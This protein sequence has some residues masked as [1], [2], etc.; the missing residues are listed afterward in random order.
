MN[1]K[2]IVKDASQIDGWF[3]GGQMNFIHQHLVNLPER[4]LIVEIGTYRGRSTYLVA[5]SVPKSYVITI[6]PC[7]FEWPNEVDKAGFK[8]VNETIDDRA[9]HAGNV[10]QWVTTSQEAAKVFNMPIDFL[11]IDGLHEQCALD[12]ELWLPKV[13]KGGLVAF[14][15]YDEPHPE[16]Y[17]NVNKLLAEDKGFEMVEAKELMCVIRKVK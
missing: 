15:D 3:T 9:L 11:F 4:S 1:L 16:V 10:M 13:K 5:K 6:D 8:L 7:N 12:M 14:H 17:N 2:E